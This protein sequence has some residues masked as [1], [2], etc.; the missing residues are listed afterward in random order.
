MSHFDVQINLGRDVAKY[1]SN[2]QTLSVPSLFLLKKY[3]DYV[4]KYYHAALEPTDFVNAADESRKKINSW[5][6]SQTNG[7]VWSFIIKALL[8][9]SLW[10]KPCAWHC[11]GCQ[12][13]KALGGD[14]RWSLR[15]GRAGLGMGGMTEG[16]EHG[17]MFSANILRAKG[18][19]GGDHRK[20]TSWKH[21]T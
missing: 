13:K 15:V 17:G 18:N 6:E 19:Q 3:L 4:E 14:L 21:N 1:K 10:V 7:R 16:T 12:G 8:E 2:F 5:V 20:P 11:S 9:Y